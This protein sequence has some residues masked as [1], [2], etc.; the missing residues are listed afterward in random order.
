M[1]FTQ[2]PSDWVPWMIGLI[3]LLGTVVDELIRRSKAG[4]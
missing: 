1:N 4:R 3:L 2:T